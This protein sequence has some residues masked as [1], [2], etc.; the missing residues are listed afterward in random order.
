M[1]IWHG[2]LP[3]LPHSAAA[4]TMAG[5]LGIEIIGLGDDTLV[6]RMPVD[7]RTRQPVGVLHGGA[8]VAL[9]ETLMSFAARLTVDLVRYQVFGQ[10][11]N[12]NH[13]RPVRSGWVTGTARPLHIG[14]TTQ[15]WTCEIRDEED[16][17]AC[18]SRMTVAV[19]PKETPRP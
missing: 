3:A 2:D 15:V 7:R 4:D 9:A 8:S 18:I 10:E 5:N 12:A 19:V 6:G 13:L 1:A 11:I 14:R 17:L 16:R